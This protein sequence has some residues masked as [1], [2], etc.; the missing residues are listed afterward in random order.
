MSFHPQT[1]QSPS[2][3][4]PGTS[5]LTSSMN[6][7]VP[8]T[9]TTL[10]TPAHSVNGSASQPS[11]M[12]QDIVMGDDTPHKRKRPLEDLGDREQKKVH[13]EDSKTGIEAL[14]LDVGEK[15]L[16]CQTPHHERLPRITEDLFEMFNLTG[17]AAEVAREKPNGEKNALRKTYKGQIKKLGILGRFDSVAQDWDAPRES[18]GDKKREAYHGFRELLEIPDAEFWGTR[19]DPITNGLSSAVKF[20]LSKA[21]AM[22]KG[23]IPA[24]DWDSSVLGDIPPGGIEALKQ[25]LA[26]KATAPG[27]PSATT[28]NPFMRKQQQGPPGAV[29]PQRTTKKRGYG[30]N[31]YEGYGEGFPDDGY[32]TGDG[33]DRGGQKR[34]KKVSS[35]AALPS[36][37]LSDP[38]QDGGNGQ[39]FPN[40]MRPQGYGA[41]GA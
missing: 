31:T 30:E 39:V 37:C 25:G 8:S 5:D 40:A 24:K 17:I 26:G 3:F 38:L 41:V 32:S 23:P 12:S 9:T 10:P 36:M 21:T 20:N 34:R 22:A 14:H 1:P 27:T 18:D 13:I 29:R 16:L 33:D 4:S 35:A 6:S 28:P 2:Q 11:D 19:Q 7:T 15:Y